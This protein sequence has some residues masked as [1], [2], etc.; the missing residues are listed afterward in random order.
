[1]PLFTIAGIHPETL[2]RHSEVVEA[3]DAEEA[4]QKMIASMREHGEPGFYIAAVFAGRFTAI[5]REDNAAWTMLSDSKDAKPEKP[6]RLPKSIRRE[7]MRHPTNVIS[8]A[9]ALQ[10]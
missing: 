8:F 6:R 9:R 1:M 7:I 5:D 3:A 2:H 4:Q 10:R